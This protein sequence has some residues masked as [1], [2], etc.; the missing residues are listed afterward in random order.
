[1][2]QPMAHPDPDGEQ[3]DTWAW[4]GDAYNSEPHP[5]RALHDTRGSR[6]P[7]RHRDQPMTADGYYV[8]ADMADLH[9]WQNRHADLAATLRTILAMCQHTE[10]HHP[11]G[12]AHLARSI[13]E[14]IEQATEWPGR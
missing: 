9:E 2:T 1:M 5:V 10:Q 7:R 4:S 6:R 12:P 14:V 3:D 13:R 11:G 8:E